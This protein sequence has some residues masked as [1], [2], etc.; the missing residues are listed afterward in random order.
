M[1]DADGGDDAEAADTPA[2]GE[3]KTRGAG[4]D[5]LTAARAIGGATSVCGTTIVRLPAFTDCAGDKVV[6]TRGAGR[7]CG[8]DRTNGASVAS[9]GVGRLLDDDTGASL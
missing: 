6:S 8:G 4:T 2:G 9:D 1:G 3:V 5:E 7:C